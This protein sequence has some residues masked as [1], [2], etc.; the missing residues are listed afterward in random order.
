M[1]TVLERIWSEAV[2][3]EFVFSFF[4]FFNDCESDGYAK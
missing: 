1:R 2:L 3:L 4:V